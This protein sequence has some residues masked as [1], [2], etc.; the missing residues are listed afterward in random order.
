MSISTKFE[1][2]CKSIR[3][4]QDDVDTISSRYKR[5][6]KQ[7]NIDYWESESET[8]HSMYVGSYGRDTD[9]HA[10]DID[11]LFKLPYKVYERINNYTSNGQSQLLQEV[12]DSLKNTYSSS[13]IGGDGQVVKINF[14]DG[15]NFEIV[16]CF[17]TTD[18]SFKYPDSNNGG[19]WKITNPKPEIEAIRK[20]ND[21]WNG[22]LK[23]LCRM[24]RDWKYEWSIEMCGLLIDTLSYNFMKDWTYRSYSFSVYHYMTR[25]IFCFLKDQKDEQTYWYAPGSNQL[26]WRKD[27]FMYK[28]LQCYNFSLEAIEDESKNCTNSANSI[29]RKIYGSKF[30]GTE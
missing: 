26:V 11:M 18:D 22:N 19:N 3:I 23:R 24:L 7:L 6:T 21:E 5:I 15:I 17:L 25:D 20:A 8:E 29:W 30:R 9:I 4:K 28:A 14:S 10:S 13:Y 1:D 16:P 2:F 12:K 27:K